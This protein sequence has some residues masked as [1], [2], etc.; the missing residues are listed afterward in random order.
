MIFKYSEI[1]RTPAKRVGLYECALSNILTRCK[2]WGDHDNE[3]CLTPKRSPLCL[4]LFWVRCPYVSLRDLDEHPSE[5]KHSSVFLRSESL[6]TAKTSE[7]TLHTPKQ[8][9]TQAT[10]H[11][12]QWSTQFVAPMMCVCVCVCSYMKSNGNSLKVRQQINAL[13]L[14]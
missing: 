5:P 11:L 7:R 2:L 1:L 12:Q 3:T 9:Q 8:G 14:G 13:S 6:S 10:L 4:V